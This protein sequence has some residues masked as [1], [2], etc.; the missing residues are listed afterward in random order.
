MSKGRA[1][2]VYVILTTQTPYREV[3]PGL[4]KSNINTKIGLKVN[5]KEA[6]KVISGDYDTLMNLRGKGHGKI[7][8]ANGEKEIQCFRIY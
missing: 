5:T 2:E 4:L 6:S 3:L 8:T 7:F 1:A